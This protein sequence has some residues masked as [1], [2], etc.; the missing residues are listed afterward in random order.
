MGTWTPALNLTVP[1]SFTYNFNPGANQCANPL[2][3]QLTVQPQVEPVFSH[4]TTLCQ[5]D[6][7][8][9]PT[10]A[11][12]G[13]T[14]A[15]N[16]QVNSQQ[17]GVTTVTFTPDAGQCSNSVNQTI[18]VNPLPSNGIS[19][20]GIT[21]TAAATGVAYQWI[22]CSTNQ[23]V[24]GATNQSF[25]TTEVV[26]TY[27]V[28]VTAN[29]CSDTSTCISVDQSGISEGDFNFGLI[30]NPANE[31]VLIQWDTD[32]V[33]MIELLDEAGKIVRRVY[34]TGAAQQVEFSLAQ[35][36]AGVYHVRLSGAENISIKKLIKL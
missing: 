25:T 29:G 28:I 10:T 30:P 12:N 1:G 4:P 9:L 5:N 7:F 6:A 23:P 20:N 27:A 34:L 21:L 32:A 33:H 35:I 24:G 14:G 18:T 8:M 3:V 15:W 2:S 11:Q 19:Q 13:I 31:S 16:P 36:A 17:V 22:D 26:G